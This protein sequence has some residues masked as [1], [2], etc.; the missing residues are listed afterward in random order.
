MPR[1]LHGRALSI[2]D[3]WFVDLSI[4][5]ARLTHSNPLGVGSTWT[6]QLP[7]EIG[8][9]ILSARV[10]W[11]TAVTKGPSAARARPPCY[12]SGV[13]F[14]GITEAQQTA[15]AEF[16]RSVSPRREPGR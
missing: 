7:S 4:A 1:A 10:A 9:L 6:V 3:L 14:I 5:G 2:V 16:L 8:S 13:E 12:E 15:L 11:S